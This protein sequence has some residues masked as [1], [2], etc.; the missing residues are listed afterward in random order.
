M[1]ERFNSK[2]NGKIALYIANLFLYE[3]IFLA[4]LMMCYIN[5]FFYYSNGYLVFFLI[6]LILFILFGRLFNTFEIGETTTTDLFLS[7][8]LTLIFSS[9]LIYFILC[10][11]TLRIIPLWPILLMLLIQ[12]V[13]GTVLIYLENHYIRA[14]FPPVKV[15]AIYG[16]SHYNL[17]GKLN[18]IRDL[19]ISV[20][21]TIDLKDIDYEKLDEL[22][23]GTD[24]VVTLD[25]HHENKKKI[26]K[27]CYARKMLIY[28]V[29]S[30]TDMLLAS[31]D[32][33]HIV[34]SPILKINKFGPSQ[35]ERIVK[36]SIDVF[37]S[38]ILLIIAS[39]IMLAVA[40][41]IKVQDSGDVFYKQVR[42]TKD[43]KEFKIIKFRS[44]VMNAEKNTG[45][46]L[47]K[48]NDDRITP[49]GRFIRKTR[50]DEL[51]QLI[52]ILNG[53]MSFVG[54]RPE[55]PEIYDEICMT[56]PEFRYRLVVKAG[57]TGYAQVYGKYNTS[58]RDKLLLDLYYIENYSIVDDIK[59]ILLTL[60]IIF[61]KE[62][63]EGV[64]DEK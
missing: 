52:N 11:I 36:R 57:L 62:A 10:L 12:V 9:I 41:A 53:E 44:M 5:Y 1:S 19:S 29:P 64:S 61:N 60:K 28:D 22:L 45:A 4:T 47:A 2:E 32:I 16:E 14:N 15:V 37:G 23:E 17:I 34:D 63:A 40:I 24:G 51:P 6:Y 43:E 31:S 38:L 3:I 13:I 26:F 50:L 49:V 46:V 56:M 25:V 20:V 54:P 21:K 27:A 7:S 30:I 18:N 8:S 35:I 59:L 42:L 58:L 55:R 33:L 39:P 48:E